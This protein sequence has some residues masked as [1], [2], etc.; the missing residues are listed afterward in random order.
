MAGCN[1][2]A[3]V[4]A[5]TRRKNL[6]NEIRRRALAAVKLLR[7]LR[8]A[9]PRASPYYLIAELNRRRCRQKL[10][11]YGCTGHIGPGRSAGS[12]VLPASCRQL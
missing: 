9:P 3:M 6:Q 8:N 7:A 10:F 12:D 11:R 1:S 2:L 4:T 5:G